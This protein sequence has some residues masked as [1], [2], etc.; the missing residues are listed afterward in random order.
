MVLDAARRFNL[1]LMPAEIRAPSPWPS[2]TGV[3]AEDPY[4]SAE[5]DDLYASSTLT[6]RAGFKPKDE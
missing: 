6:K 4:L 2:A 1:C 3:G 5:L